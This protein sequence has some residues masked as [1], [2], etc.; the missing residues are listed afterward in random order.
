MRRTAVLLLVALLLAALPSSAGGA[1]AR[2]LFDAETDCF[3]AVP[4]AADPGLDRRAV[5]LD[6]HVLVDGASDA[7][8]RSAV[9][10][11]RRAYGPLGIDLRATYQRVR[12]P[13]DGRASTYGRPMFTASTDAAM[14]AAKR[15]VPHGRPPRGAELVYL[16]TNKDLYVRDVDG[17]RSYGVAGM[18]DCIGGVL[19]PHRAF[20]VGES[21]E[22]APLDVAGLAFA[23][24]QAAKVLAHEL[25]HLLGAHHHYANCGEAVPAAAAERTTDAC[26]LM[27]NDVGL[28]SLRFSTVNLAV[29]RGHALAAV[30]PGR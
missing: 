15:A 8:A 26:T 4:A 3:E 13:A 14:A 12:L 17:G 25:G 5:R 24:E 19:D 21:F 1:P 22:P 7:T 6:L 11:A 18:A 28:V 23:R 2:L 16:L 9:A 10:A 29:V 20:A 27:F 30:P